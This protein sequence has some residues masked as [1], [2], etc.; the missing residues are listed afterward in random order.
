MYYAFVAVRVMFI[1]GFE[2]VDP[3]I[4]LLFY[5]MSML[6]LKKSLSILT[7][8][9]EGLYI[10]DKI[11]EHAQR[12]KLSGGEYMMTDVMGTC[13]YGCINMQCKSSSTTDA[14]STTDQI[15]EHHVA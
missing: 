10:S 5:V 14:N 13:N 11:D 9:I 7:M 6:V 1:S 3:I 15:R 2:E 8:K 4:L 12:K